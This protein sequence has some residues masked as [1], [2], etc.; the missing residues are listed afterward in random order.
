MK[1]HNTLFHALCLTLVLLFMPLLAFGQENVSKGDANGDG[2]INAADITETI[3]YIKGHPT[4]RF[5]LSNADIDSN[6]VVNE[7][8]IK[9]IA[10]LIRQSAIS[11]EDIDAVFFFVDEEQ[12]SPDAPFAI[13]LMNDNA[14]FGFVNENS[15][16][17]L[18]LLDYYAF[19]WYIMHSGSDGVVLYYPYDPKTNEPGNRIIAY[20]EYDDHRRMGFFQADW[21]RNEFEADSIIVI[22][23]AALSRTTTRGYIRYYN[24]PL[25]SLT[26]MVMRKYSN[27]MQE[28]SDKLN[29][30]KTIEKTVTSKI[31][32]YMPKW[33]WLDNTSN[34]L[35]LEVKATS[36]WAEQ[37]ESGNPFSVRFDKASERTF[38][39]YNTD[40]VSDL[41]KDEMCDI[42]TKHFSLFDKEDVKDVQ[43]WVDIAESINKTIADEDN[44]QEAK[45]V[46]KRVWERV[47][48]TNNTIPSQM[49]DLESQPEYRV[50]VN[51]SNISSSSATLSGSY[52]EV[53]GGASI[54]KMGYRIIGPDGEEDIDAWKLPAKQI[55][56]LKPGTTYSVYAYLSSTST[57]SGKYTSKTITF[58][59]LEDNITVSPESLS[60]DAEGGTKTVTVTATEGVKWSVTS[61]P[62]WTKVSTSD[63]VLTV[64][65]GEGDEEERSG[66]IVIEAQMLSGEVKNVTINISQEAKKIEI[67][68]T[69][70]IVFTGTGCNAILNIKD[71][72]YYLKIYVDDYVMDEGCLSKKPTTTYVS[73]DDGVS[74][75]IQ[76][77]QYSASENEIRRSYDIFAGPDRIAIDMV[78]SN[79]N[80]QTPTLDYRLTVTGHDYGNIVLHMTGKR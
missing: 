6:G 28:L 29:I 2:V 63:N 57:A 11:K 78:I 22:K 3:N 71:G 18:L 26:T 39:K 44:V 30:F 74:Y 61:Y 32:S 17:V 67:P 19:Q 53:Y 43:Q 72:E 31:K 77:F 9:A 41:G 48:T 58:T 40:V 14:I 15:Q 54:F 35:N 23:P 10:D 79:L 38:E 20:N 27:T 51:V 49:M 60:F 8:D 5:I 76:N 13:S 47:I 75:S 69:G 34:V 1:S 68:T 24:D 59:T 50:N 56:N 73:F 4:E 37:F 55:T 33:V 12:V 46:S 66:S 64:T 52:V 45:R 70:D 25:K 65:V 36:S 7:E 62:G 42:F 21:E 80:T 16:V